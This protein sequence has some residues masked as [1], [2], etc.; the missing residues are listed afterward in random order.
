MLLY[1]VLMAGTLTP[2]TAAGASVRMVGPGAP[3]SSYKHLLAVSLQILFVKRN[4]TYLMCDK[5]WVYS[6]RKDILAA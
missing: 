3:V 1:N 4:R 2:V 5:F 6:H